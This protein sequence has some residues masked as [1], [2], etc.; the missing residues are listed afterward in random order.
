[1]QATVANADS[2]AQESPSTPGLVLADHPAGGTDEMPESAFKELS[3]VA[4]RLPL[5]LDVM[6]PIPRFQVRNLAELR[7][8][9]IIESQWNAGEDLPLTAGEAILAWT[10]FEI[11]ST[12]L[13]VRL[14][15]LA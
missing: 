1:M 15:R 7:P 9:H 14:T 10:E 12:K 13:A 3:G 4:L 2:G 11:V 6:I 5:Q 8:G